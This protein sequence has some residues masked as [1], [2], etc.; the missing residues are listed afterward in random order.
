M[1]EHVCTVIIFGAS[2]FHW[3]FSTFAVNVVSCLYERFQIE[4]Q[5]I[6]MTYCAPQCEHFFVQAFSQIVNQHERNWCEKSN[7]FSLQL[8]KIMQFSFVIV[9]V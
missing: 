9:G 2:S 1:G 5:S 6:S 8:M 4:I 3:L 7:H